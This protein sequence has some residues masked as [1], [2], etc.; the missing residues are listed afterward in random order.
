M[1]HE[2]YMDAHSE[3]NPDDNPLARAINLQ[4]SIDRHN[5][6]VK[7][8]LGHTES[9]K[10]YELD[11]VD[12]GLMF[13][14]SQ[15]SKKDH[16]E[17]LTKLIA[18]G[19]ILTRSN[20]AREERGEGVAYSTDHLC[21]VLELMVTRLHAFHHKNALAEAEKYFEGQI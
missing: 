8:F 14:G 20:L 9:L 17:V 18:I 2:E 3:I 15:F 11:M 21:G 13:N 7:E 4:T 19:R 6:D 10:R 12:R 5:M 1:A 16:R